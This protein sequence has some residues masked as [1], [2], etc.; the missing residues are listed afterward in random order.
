MG[1]SCSLSVGMCNVRGLGRVSL[2][3]VCEVSMPMKDVVISAIPNTIRAARRPNGTE[4]M[5]E[6]IAAVSAWGPKFVDGKLRA[7]DGA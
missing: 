1:S 5:Q 6:F 2:M 7:D 4:E 3:E